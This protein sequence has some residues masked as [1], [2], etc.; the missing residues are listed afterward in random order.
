M[1]RSR[2]LGCIAVEDYDLTDELALIDGLEAGGTYDA[3]TFGS[4]SSH[5]LANGSGAEQD[6]E[7]RPHAEHLRPTELGRRLPAIMSLVRDHFDATNLQWVRIFA[8]TDGILAPHVDFLEFASPGTR[9][10]IPL[11]TTPR[12]R[13]SEERT[14][15]HLRRGEV[16]AIH[17]TVPH[18]AMSPAGP[19]RLALCLD[20]A[21]TQ[22]TPFSTGHTDAPAPAEIHL[23][24]RPTISE[25][26]LAALIATG[27]SMTRE[28]M[29]ERFR[30][31]AQAHFDRDS[32]AVDAFDWFI[33]AAARSADPTLA[34]RAA[35]FR[36]FCVQQRGYQERFDW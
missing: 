35:A 12:S 17:A 14:V 30:D 27:T 7:F 6:T 29:R 4:W 34:R 18:S 3:F 9:L 11:R 22:Q 2:R 31:F 10:Q 19:A 28:N 21:G 25:E 5:V 8:L 23:I 13:H 32:H 1:L 26:E 33:A 15:Y 16:W 20:F 36:T 24:D